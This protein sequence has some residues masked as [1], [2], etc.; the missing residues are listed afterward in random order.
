VF[1]HKNI[2]GGNH[3]DNLFGGPVVSA[4]PGD[5]SGVDLTTLTPAQL[6]ALNT[7]IAGENSFVAS[8][9]AN[10][11]DFFI[12]GHDHHHYYSY[13]TSPD[14]QSKTRQIIAQS[15][16]SKFY[17]PK[18]P[19]SALDTPI[20][21]DLGRI[22]YYIFNVKGSMVT[23]DYYGDAA[24][25]NNYQGP[26]NFV[27]MATFSYS[28]NGAGN[29]VP[30]GGSYV[31][32]DDTSVASGMDKGFVGTTMSIL[33][34]VNSSPATTNYGK[35][36]SAYV[37]TSWSQGGGVLTS[38]VLGLSGMSTLS[39]AQTDPYVL[40]MNFKPVL[41]YRALI[42]MG[43]FGLLAK[44]AER[45]WVPAVQLNTPADMNFVLGPWNASYGLG[46]YGVDLASGT[47]W[48]VLNYNGEFAVG[49]IPFH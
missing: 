48:A 44:N 16:S 31:M 26:F 34:G 4:D 21:Q 24:G 27:K 3:K 46:T 23:V 35:P 28:L 42:R 9:Q 47:A 15:D 10:K 30:E 11:V 2:L 40:S 45:K 7:K 43:R 19:V 5:G 32:S 17:I 18:T 13:L 33:D 8:M 38:D 14:G 6:D 22:G 36:Y 29:L 12:S 49:K 39:G 20:Q 1:A 25:A 37:T 41:L